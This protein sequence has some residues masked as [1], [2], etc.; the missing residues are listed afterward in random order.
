MVS[1]RGEQRTGQLPHG[2]VLDTS[3]EVHGE[4][5]HVY[6]CNISLSV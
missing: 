1:R 6:V 3:D 4:A 5:A 2:P